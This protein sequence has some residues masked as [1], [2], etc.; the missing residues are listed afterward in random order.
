MAQIGVAVYKSV[1]FRGVG[2]EFSNVQHFSRPFGTVDDAERNSIIDEI[3]AIE[4]DLHS[5]DVTF[6][7]ARLW[8]SGGTKAENE[9]LLEKPLT[10]VGNLVTDTSLDRERA[11]LIQWPAGKDVRGHPVTLK[12][13]YH[14]CGST[15]ALGFTTSNKQNTSQ[16]ATATRDYFAGKAQG[17]KVVGATVDTWSLCAKSGRGTTGDAVCHPWL[18]HHQLGDMWR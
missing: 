10:G 5:A 7:R 16:L 9:M 11:I 6:L 18:E 17:I 4:R 8:S 1:S 3:V 15:S 13:W 12:K 14:T 2:Q